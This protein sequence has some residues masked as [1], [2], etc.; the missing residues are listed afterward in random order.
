MPSLTLEILF[1]I[2]VAIIIIFYGSEKNDKRSRTDEY[3]KR[4]VKLKKS[5]EN[6]TVSA[7]T[8]FVICGLIVLC[9]VFSVIMAEII[10]KIGD[11]ILEG[12]L[13]SIFESCMGPG[14][15]ECSCA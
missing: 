15:H 12:I 11:A 14:H 8:I 2:I 1:V 7:K 13:H 3:K 9:L 6:V 5:T 10:P 4:V